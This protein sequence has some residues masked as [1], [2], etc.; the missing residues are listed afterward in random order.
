[1]DKKGVHGGSG[2]FLKFSGKKNLDKIVELEEKLPEKKSQKNPDKLKEALPGKEKPK[3][4]VLVRERPKKRSPVKKKRPRVLKEKAKAPEEK[5]EDLAAE[6]QARPQ[7]KREELVE[8]PEGNEEKKTETT[9]YTK[10]L[11]FGGLLVVFLVVAYVFFQNIEPY[12]PKEDKNYTFPMLGKGVKVCEDYYLCFLENETWKRPPYNAGANLTIANRIS[13]QNETEISSF[14]KHDKINLVFGSSEESGQGNS[15]MIISATPFTYY[16]SYYFSYRGENKTISG[17][18][19]ANYTSEEPAVIILGPE[20]GATENSM[21]YDGK[22]IVVQSESFDY[23]SLLLGK[24][25]L[26][27][28]KG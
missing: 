2:K 22:N 7:E 18:L 1:M 14:F 3:I 12:T 27:A 10:Y 16:L 25:L 13:V 6:Q 8:E 17:Y 21:K 24:L 26:L 11:I 9:S 19:L 28:V 20:T 23:L 5:K 15:G 4:E